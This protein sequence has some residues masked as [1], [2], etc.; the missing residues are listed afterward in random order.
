MASQPSTVEALL[1]CL[2]AAGPA[3]ARKM[4]GEYCIYLDGKPVGLVCD[5]KLFVKPTAAG[6]AL[7]PDAPEEPPYLGAK[8]HLM[9]PP[10]GWA[11]RA[12]LCRLV[13]ATFRELARP[14]PRR[15]KP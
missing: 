15:K 4:F 8:P 14:K 3:T 1:D 7:A 9:I 6:R 11:D 2:S 12:A 5:D 13:Q 10:D